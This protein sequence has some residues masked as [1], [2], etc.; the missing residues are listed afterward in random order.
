MKKISQ[1]AIPLSAT[2]KE[3]VQTVRKALSQAVSL[4]EKAV[5]MLE[6]H[7]ESEVTRNLAS[8]IKE[9]SGKIESIVEEY[10][11]RYLEEMVEK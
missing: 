2:E 10:A 9:L 4:L 8:S 1:R 6:K 3:L 7:M 11:D 5:D